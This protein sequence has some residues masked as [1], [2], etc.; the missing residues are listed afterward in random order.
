M[1]RN[2]RN[3]KECVGIRWIRFTISNRGTTQVGVFRFPVYLDVVRGV[4]DWREGSDGDTDSKDQIINSEESRQDGLRSWDLSLE[5]S[6]IGLC[7][8]LG[9]RE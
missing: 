6:P 9:F 2:P 3:K 1:V 5:E 8:K 4:V 7:V